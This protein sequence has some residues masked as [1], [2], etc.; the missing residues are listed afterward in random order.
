M[1]PLLARLDSTQTRDAGVIRV[2]SPSQEPTRTWT[3]LP[4]RLTS[5]PTE[6]RTRHL[7]CISVTR[8]I[9]LSASRVISGANTVHV[10]NVML[11]FLT[12]GSILLVL[13]DIEI[14]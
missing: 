6:R 12:F 3:Q 1:Y 9:V 11:I 14:A 5:F 7:A 2:T 13:A 4:I 10:S 8:D